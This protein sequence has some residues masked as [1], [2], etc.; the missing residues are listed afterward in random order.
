[1]VYVRIIKKILDFFH[2]RCVEPNS[3]ELVKDIEETLAE[4][5]RKNQKIVGKIYTSSG[6]NNQEL[7]S[8]TV[9]FAYDCLESVKDKHAD[10]ELVKALLTQI[11]YRKNDFEHKRHDPDGIVSGTLVD[12]E[13]ALKEK[14]LP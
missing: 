13:N 14:R 5:M 3:L 11:K 12:I 1:M 2:D 7:V 10:T 4:V 9:Y 6:Y 8:D